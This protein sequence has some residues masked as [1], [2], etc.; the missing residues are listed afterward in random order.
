MN[1]QNNRL[2]IWVS[3]PEHLEKVEKIISFYD[4]LD[5]VFLISDQDLAIY[6]YPIISSY[7]ITFYNIKVAFLDLVDCV[8]VVNKN[9]IAS[10]DITLFCKN[11][12][13]LESKIDNNFFKNIR[14][15][16]L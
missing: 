2:G 11:S 4:Q 6:K 13:I 3:K 16:E 8:C 10:K 7:Y 12:E 1:I 14:V 15:V 5:D 9:N